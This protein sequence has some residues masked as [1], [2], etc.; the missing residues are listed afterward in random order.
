MKD[1]V[2]LVDS[3][4][5][6]GK[7]F[8]TKHNIEYVKMLLNWTDEKGV[9]HENIA[10][11]D[12]E[13][14]SMKE[15]YDIIR[16]GIR[17][18]TSM[19]SQQ[20]YMGFFEKYLKEKKDVLYI[21]CSSGLSNSIN[22]AKKLVETEIKDKY[23][24]NKVVIIDSLRAGMS[25]GMIIMEAQKLKDEGKSIDEVA[26]W[27][28]ENKLKYLEVGIPETLTYLKRAG[29][30]SGPKALMGNMI[31]LK[32]I[33]EFDDKGSNIA[34]NKAIGRRKAYIKMAE[35]IKEHIDDPENQEIYLMHADCKD[36]DV[37]AFKDEILKAVKVKNIIVEPLGPIIGASSGPGTIIVNYR[38][39]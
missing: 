30:V 26:K 14:L 18:Y 37:K 12:W 11:L 7:E 25:L 39:K 15:F 29:R 21:A 3:C 19:P 2:I 23:P 22:I 13:T 10:D 31:G 34:V 36:D 27:V 4:C 33:L 16:R 17:F 9:E 1:Y 6:L 8:R 28:E 32:P 5:D 20:D 24:N 35:M 38:G